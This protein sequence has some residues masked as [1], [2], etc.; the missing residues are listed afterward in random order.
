MET[1]EDAA[2]ELETHVRGKSHPHMSLKV[3]YY[4]FAILSVLAG[5]GAHPLYKVFSL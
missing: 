5:T 4:V 3:V 2:V 1:K